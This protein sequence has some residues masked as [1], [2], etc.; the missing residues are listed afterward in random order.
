MQT[1]EG[2]LSNWQSLAMIAGV[3][4]PVIKLHHLNSGHMAHD[5]SL[6]SYRLF[7]LKT[8][9][10]KRHSLSSIRQIQA[11]HSI[12]GVEES[13]EGTEVGRA[14]RIG[15]HVDAPFFGVEPKRFQSPLLAD[16]LNSINV[17]C[18]SIIS[19]NSK[20]ERAGCNMTKLSNMN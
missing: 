6:Q 14:P 1:R 13:R 11:H 4:M 5:Q 7:W 2:K 10:Q 16:G 9:S 3:V 8:N 20:R 17:F 15:L 12:V 19:E 18:A